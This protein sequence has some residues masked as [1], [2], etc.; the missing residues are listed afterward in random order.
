[1]SYLNRDHPRIQYKSFYNRSKCLRWLT[2]GITDT[3]EMIAVEDLELTLDTQQ[4]SKD[5]SEK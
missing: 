5:D 1:M 3:N 2:T 4:Q